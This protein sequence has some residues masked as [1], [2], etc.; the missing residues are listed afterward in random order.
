[1]CGAG[2]GVE[3]GENNSLNVVVGGEEGNAL[4]RRLSTSCQNMSPTNPP[5]STLLGLE[6]GVQTL[7]SAVFIVTRSTVLG[8]LG[9][10][11]RSVYGWGGGGYPPCC[12]R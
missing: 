3:V 5:F 11:D 1:M 8:L 2:A 6:E 9:Q 4:T 7:A 12:P 10:D